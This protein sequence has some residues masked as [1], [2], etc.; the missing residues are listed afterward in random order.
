MRL[1]RVNVKV[2]QNNQLMKFDNNNNMRILLNIAYEI[3]KIY[4]H[5]SRVNTRFS[6]GSRR[7]NYG[8]SCGILGYSGICFAYS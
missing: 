1:I 7:R 5:K 6:A 4:I 8:T 2:T 3:D